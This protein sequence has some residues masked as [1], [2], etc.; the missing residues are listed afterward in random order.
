M[1]AFRLRTLVP[2]RTIPHAP[3][4]GGGVLRALSQGTEPPPI[5]PMGKLS[6]PIGQ[7]GAD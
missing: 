7:E 2:R 5:Y 1:D 3:R 4:V 6:S